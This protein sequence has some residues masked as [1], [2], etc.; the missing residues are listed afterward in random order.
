[1]GL[2]W[3]ALSER[4]P[5]AAVCGS[6]L[7]PPGVIRRTLGTSTV[8]SDPVRMCSSRSRLAPNAC[9]IGRPHVYGLAIGGADGVRQVIENV[10]AELD[11][12][13]GLL[14]ISTIAELSRSLLVPAP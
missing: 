2:E 13:M 12:T 1:M 6:R 9:L 14:G 3:P 8:A 7:K 10:V 5:Y 11:L 4:R